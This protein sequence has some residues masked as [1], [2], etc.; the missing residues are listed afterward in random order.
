MT[1]IPTG[2]RYMV[3]A[4]FFFSLMSLFVKLVGTRLPATEIVFAR[5]LFGV[6]ITY[7]FVR[8]MLMPDH[9]TVA[10][11]QPWCKEADLRRRLTFRLTSLNSRWYPSQA[12]SGL[13]CSSWAA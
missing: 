8:R 3:S 11:E 1:R 4:A 6:L 7:T 10:E 12:S 2:L 9:F 13:R 5:S